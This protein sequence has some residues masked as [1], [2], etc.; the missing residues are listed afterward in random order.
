MLN[1]FHEYVTIQYA[2]EAAEIRQKV[3]E[4]CAR[5]GDPHHRY[6]AKESPRARTDGRECFATA[7]KARI[8]SEKLRVTRM[9]KAQSPRFTLEMHADSGGGFASRLPA[10]SR[11]GNP[12]IQDSR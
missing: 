6:T 4:P 2:L 5:S 12:Q 11:G 1:S 7:S 9:F 8:T 3:V 10:R